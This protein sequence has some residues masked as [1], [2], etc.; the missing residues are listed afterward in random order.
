MASDNRQGRAGFPGFFGSAQTLTH[1][2]I[3][4]LAKASPDSEPLSFDDLFQ[5]FL[6]P[7]PEIAPIRV[8]RTRLIGTGQTEQLGPYDTSCYAMV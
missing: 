3:L 5:K 2:P 4:N 6:R 8:A 1:A 7:D